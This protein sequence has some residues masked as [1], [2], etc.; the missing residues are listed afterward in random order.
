MSVIS[1]LFDNKAYSF[2]QAFGARDITSRKMREAIKMWFAMYFDGEASTDEDDCQRLPVVIVNKLTKTVF[3][4]YEA[5]V[6][7]GK[8]AKFARMLLDRLDLIR[9]EAMQQVLVGGG[10][11]VKP[12][13]A[14]DGFVFS[15]VRRDCFIPLERSI[16]GALTSAEFAEFAEH[17]DKCYTLLE[18]RTVNS[19]GTLTIENKLYMSLDRGILGTQV[20]LGSLERYADLQSMITIPGI[21]SLGMAYMRTP[22]M[23]CVDGSPDGVSVYAPA[24]K[25]IRNINRNERQLNREFENGASRIIASCDMVRRDTDGKRKLA[26]DLFVG[27]DND[28][29]EVG[30]TIFSPAL[31]EASY[32]A[33]KQEYLRNVE[34][35]IGFKRGILSEVEAAERTATEI[36]SS[37]GD[38]NLTIQDFQQMWAD[39]ARDLLAIC[40]RLGQQYK[41]CDSS[42]FDPAEDIVI[43]WGDGVLFDR[44]RTWQEYQ[45]MVASGM[46]KPELA[47]AWYFDLPHDTPEDFEKIRTNYMPEMKALVGGDE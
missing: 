27:V 7:E 5:E 28:P 46:L 45:Q 25:L 14:N 22:L 13:L 19:A 35:L 39:M 30:I 10:C 47:L 40:D 11:F 20:P 8:K 23:N 1:A 12:I 36:T 38:Y 3:S 34:S 32:L 44:T 24:A 17:G 43:N 37:A 18:R 9:K 29:E 41:K 33:R 16:T 15:V 31:R 26:D 4:E 2:E 6:R 21:Y 42:K